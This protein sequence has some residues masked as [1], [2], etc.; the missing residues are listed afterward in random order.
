MMSRQTTTRLQRKVSTQ[1]NR[2]P[3]FRMPPRRVRNKRL[4]LTESWFVITI[5]ETWQVKTWQVPELIFVCFYIHFYEGHLSDFKLSESSAVCPSSRSAISLSLCSIFLRIFFQKVLFL[6]LPATE[7]VA[8][9]WDIQNSSMIIWTNW[10]LLVLNKIILQPSVSTWSAFTIF[11]G[12]YFRISWRKSL[13]VE[14]MFALHCWQT[15]RFP[16]HMMIHMSQ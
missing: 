5:S 4:W 15:T 3:S 16:P 8:S 7:A 9:S 10:W 12:R 13:V 6:A 11:S 14:S 2:A 1:T